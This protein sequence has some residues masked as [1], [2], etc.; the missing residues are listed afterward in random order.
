MDGG[1]GETIP[2]RSFGAVSERSGIDRQI[3]AAPPQIEMQLI[4]M[5]RPIAIFATSQHTPRVLTAQRAVPT[6]F[7]RVGSLRRRSRLA[8]GFVPEQPDQI[9]VPGSS[10]QDRYTFHQEMTGLHS[11]PKVRII[12]LVPWEDQSAVI[13]AR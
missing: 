2:P 3:Q 13:P 5:S 10:G 1:P 11:R 7:R 4:G 8:Q 9:L 6:N 12:A